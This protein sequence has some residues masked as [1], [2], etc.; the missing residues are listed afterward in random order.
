MSVEEYNAWQ[1]NHPD[2]DRPGGGFGLSC[3]HEGKVSLVSGKMAIR[4]S[5]LLLLSTIPGERIR[6]PYYGCDLY[7]LTF[8]PNDSTTHGLAIHYVRQ[9]LEQWEPRIKINT[10]DAY[11]SANDMISK[12]DI[13]LNYEIKRPKMNDELVLTLTLI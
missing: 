5:I 3:N 6:R 7:R 4:Q 2:F 9:A 8:M 13:S 11:N 10:I 12:I 1:F